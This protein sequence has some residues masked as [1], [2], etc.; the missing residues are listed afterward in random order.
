MPW[1]RLRQL[2]SKNGWTRREAARKLGDSGSARAVEPLIAALTD[3]EERVREQ[4]AESLGTICDARA[5]EP[6]ITALNDYL[7]YDVSRAAAKA[8]GELGDAR[9]VEPLI[10]ALNASKVRE[11]AASALG[12]LG[13]AR[14]AEPLIGRLRDSDRT[15]RRAAAEALIALNYVSVDQSEQALIFVAR[16]SFRDAIKLGSAA[17]EPL[18][19]V[20]E[21]LGQD[22]HWEQGYGLRRQVQLALVTI[23]DAAVEPLI[24]VLRYSSGKLEETALRALEEIGNSRA[25][26]GLMAY[27]RR[28]EEARDT[29]KAQRDQRKAEKERLVYRMMGRAEDMTDQEMIIALKR[30]CSA[31]GRSEI[32]EL[33]PLAMAIGEVLNDRGGFNEMRRIFNQAGGT[34]RLDMHWGGIGQWLG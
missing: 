11:A 21:H 13:D 16:Q 29:D 22:D 24:A 12:R 23:G 33:D 28:K 5:V 10:A 8:L 18:I 6:L 9:A 34:R 25:A 20:L 32:A 4:A 2:R 31:S 15:V 27:Q 26:E 7:F 3:S 19:M 17:V 30:Y 1:W 14:A